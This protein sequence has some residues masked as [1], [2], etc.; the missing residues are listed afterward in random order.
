MLPTHPTRSALMEAVMEAAEN[1]MDQ[2][3]HTLNR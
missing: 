3:V 1:A 2:A